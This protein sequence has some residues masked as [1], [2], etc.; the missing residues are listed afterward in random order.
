MSSEQAS[1]DDSTQV[2]SKLDQAK[3]RTIRDG[4]LLV[5]LLSILADIVVS[6]D[7][8][9]GLTLLAA[10][11]CSY[12]CLKWCL[13]DSQERHA[14]VGKFIRIV[15]LLI[16]LIGM[17]LFLLRTRGLRL[18]LIAIGKLILLATLITAIEYGIATFL[19]GRLRGGAD[20]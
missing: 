4:F 7:V 15:V 2:A 9:F 8:A 14:Q 19:I 10:L 18:G 16:P 5:T 13:F 1:P 3:R 20:L 11:A 12:F 6:E 17:P